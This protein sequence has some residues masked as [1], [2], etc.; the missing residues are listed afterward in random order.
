MKSG[1]AVTVRV[2]RGIVEEETGTCEPLAL[3][4]SVRERLTRCLELFGELRY[5]VLE[6]FLGAA[7]SVRIEKSEEFVELN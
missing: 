5:P 3:R 2:V 1:V 6:A 7:K 4:L